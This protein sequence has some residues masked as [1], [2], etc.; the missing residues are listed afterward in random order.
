MGFKGKMELTYNECLDLEEALSA[1]IAG[2]SAGL[3]P[4]YKSGQLIVLRDKIK[5]YRGEIKN[6]ALRG[7]S[8]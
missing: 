2:I 7:V 8:K 3:T 4:A 1:A 5:E 6:R